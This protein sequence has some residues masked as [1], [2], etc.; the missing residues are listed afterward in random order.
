MRT[1]NFIS[2]ISATAI[3]LLS[4]ISCNKSYNTRKPS[5]KLADA[6]VTIQINGG[7]NDTLD[8]VVFTMP[9]FDETDA[10]FYHLNR[11][12]KDVYSGK[13]P[14]QISKEL[15]GV[16]LD[17]ENFHCGCVAILSQ[18]DPVTITFN[19]TEQGEYQSIYASNNE[20]PMEYEK[21]TDTYV[22]YCNYDF[23]L[24]KYAPDSLYNNWE[25]V[26]AHELDVLL[27]PVKDMFEKTVVPESAKPW[28]MN[29]MLMAWAN[30][31][32]L[33]YTYIANDRKKLNVPT[34][35]M[36]AWS[37]LDSLDY[38]EV[39]L[40]H[41]PYQGLGPFLSSILKYAGGG[42]EPIGDTPVAEWKS[43]AKETLRPAIKEPTDLLL[44]LL[45]GMS[46]IRQIVNDE[47]PLSETQLKNLDRA[48]PDDIDLIIKQYN[49]K[50]IKVNENSIDLS[51][52]NFSLTEYVNSEFNGQP[53]VV[54]IWNAWC[55][56]CMTAINQIGSK[57]DELPDNVTYL[58]IS[59]T[60]SDVKDWRRTS[61]E[62]HGIS[63]RISKESSDKLLEEFNLIG[64]P[65]YILFN[66]NHK[67]I[68]A[69]TGFMGLENY[70]Q[71]VEE[72]AK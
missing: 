20:D 10:T 22:Y 48:Y 43:Y 19:F 46:Y 65:S 37:W 16:T 30:F 11:I 51:D 63:V 41:H 44:D 8:V 5:I 47:Q 69:K 53:V 33:P 67:I 40:M 61:R 17:G 38:S 57:H 27:P 32:Y 49:D 12:N 18:D 62:I 23:Y 52:E 15:C 71:K 56:P 36:E 29:Y 28:F 4:F 70:K 72:L 1:N 55:G 21:L 54:D 39:M 42:L 14:L 66:K 68:Y 24:S 34:P 35:P 3:I 9:I 26:R 7:H 45:S 13:V 58:Y 64:F 31:E 59:D 2:V 60:S 6:E 25:A 50:L